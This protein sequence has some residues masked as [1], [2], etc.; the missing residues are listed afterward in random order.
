M[1][2]DHLPNGIER[3]AD[4]RRKLADVLDLLVALAASPGETDARLA[5]DWEVVHLCDR[6]LGILTSDELNKAASFAWR[7]F[8]VRD[9]SEVVEERLIER[10]TCQRDRN[11]LASLVD[12]EP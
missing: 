1:A 8:A 4:R 12:Y 3:D 10:V 2:L 5:V 9:V 11:R 7:D 6:E